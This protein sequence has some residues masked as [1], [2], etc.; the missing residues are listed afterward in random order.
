MDLSFLD[1]IK[2]PV[3]LKLTREG[4]S[5][6]QLKA[7][8]VKAYTEAVHMFYKQLFTRQLVSNFME[9]GETPHLPNDPTLRAIAERA[10]ENISSKPPYI[11]LTVNPREDIKLNELKSKVEKYVG[12]SIVTSFA[13]VYEVRDVDSGL[14]CHILFQYK[15]KPY[16]VKRCTKNTFKNITNVD[17]PHCLNFKYVEEANLF[18][19]YQYLLGN[20]TEKKLKS[21]NATKL[22][23][24]TN[25]LQPIYESN[26]TLPCRVALKTGPPETVPRIAFETESPQ[27]VP[28]ATEAQVW[29]SK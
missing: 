5:E 11:L 14:H 25:N 18:D 20:K 23:R 29:N 7:T 4:I 19:K 9:T 27:P 2:I 6:S 1:E 12:R 8:V 17:N 10:S 28:E 26:P 15:G 13:Y 22:Y 16:D 3:P 21:V 24:L